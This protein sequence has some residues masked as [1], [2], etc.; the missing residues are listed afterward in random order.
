VGTAQLELHPLP[1]HQQILEFSDRAASLGC[2]RI[3][4][5]PLFLLPGVHVMEDIPE[6]VQTARQL[7]GESRILDVRPHLGRETLGLTR[8]VASQIQGLQAKDPRDRPWILVSHGSRR[9]GANTTVEEMAQRLD[10]V[11]AYWSRSPSLEERVEQLRAAGDRQIGIV[12]YF[13]FTG[14]ITD[15]IGES[16][17]QLSQQQPPLEFQLA[18]PL[19]PSDELADLIL[20]LTQ[21]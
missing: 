8:L 7:L 15:A 18:E 21:K 19:G 2:E 17:R 13:L 12:P 6:E 5:L 4:I 14:G 11:T 3:C 20:H 1:L 9:E 16:V 10:A